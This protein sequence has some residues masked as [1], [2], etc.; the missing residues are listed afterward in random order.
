MAKVK[1][2]LHH[3]MRIQP[4]R[5]KR[6]IALFAGAFSFSLLV[7][8][9]S[10]IV[11]RDYNNSCDSCELWQQHLDE[12]KIKIIGLEQ[13]VIVEHLAIK[14]AHQ[15]IA[16][17]E[18]HI[19]QLNKTTAFYRSIMSPEDTMIGLNVQNL[20]I[21]PLKIANTYRLSW[22]L[23]QAGRN[24]SFIKGDLKLNVSESLNNAGAKAVIGAKNTVT[25]K[26][27]FRYFQEF[28]VDISLPE[29]F[30]PAQVQIIATSHGKNSQKIIRKFTWLTNED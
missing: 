24:K 9:S 2:S 19:Q 28:E 27:K 6:R 21:T 18:E 26:F 29:K 3:K 20:H 1:G 14:E 25:K 7:A 17:Q 12:S 13:Q 23:I 5:P 10:F 4:H 15:L 11:G 8:F 30:N 22:V 16:E